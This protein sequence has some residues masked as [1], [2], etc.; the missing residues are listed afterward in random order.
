MFVR[1]KDA[2]MNQNKMHSNPCIPQSRLE[3]HTPLLNTETKNLYLY[4]VA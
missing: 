3:D 1:I 4:N 2:A